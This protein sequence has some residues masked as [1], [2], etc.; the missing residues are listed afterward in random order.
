MG[1]KSGNAGGAQAG[2][3]KHWLGN[4][5]PAGWILAD[6]SQNLSRTLY[7]R[8]FRV[9]G[10]TYGAG[11]GT[12]TFGIPDLRGVFVRGQDLGRGLDAGRQL[13]TLQQSQ[14]KAHTHTLMTLRNGMFGQQA[15]GSGG[16]YGAFNSYETSSS[17]G[18][19]AHPLN[20]AGIPIIKY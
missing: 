12:T 8:L 6:G 18:A 7:A 5:V 9:Y 20:M 17:G 1:I 14:N 16:Q 15:E 3:Y 10:T 4:V 13:G 19:H 2:D 11:N